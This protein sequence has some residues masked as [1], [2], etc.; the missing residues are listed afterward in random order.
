[1]SPQLLPPLPARNDLPVSPEPIRTLYRR[2]RTAAW[3]GLLVDALLAAVKLTAGIAGHS[4]ALIADA[5]NS[6]GDGLSSGV[7]LYALGV[8]QQPADDEHPYG[9]SRAEA[10]AAV[11]IAVVI[12]MSAI[13]VAVESLRR[14][15]TVHPAPPIWALGVAAGNAVV[16]EGMYRYKRRVA[17]RTGSE[18]LV[19]GAWDHRSDALCSIAVLIGLAGV[20]YGG[21]AMMWADEVAAVVV[22]G[23]IL[24]MSITLFRRNAS[25]LMDQQ[26]DGDTVAMIRKIAEATPGVVR[27][28]QVRARRSGM[29]AFVD[30]HVEVDGA[31]T[32]T[33]G[34]RIGHDVQR[35]VIS[36]VTAVSEVLVHI[37][38][39]GSS[40]AT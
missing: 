9:H 15:G 10:I 25:L 26:C 39:A 7:I 36:G 40:Q 23:F 31:S 21:S 38:P 20:R 17:A 22:V 13:A 30:I 34:H 5:V 11:S 3:V 4:V 24:L 28:E 2:A 6:I 12:A 35:R 29:E 32:V 14:L 27:V 33:E 8:A 18:S 1:M 37:E 19:A 16:K